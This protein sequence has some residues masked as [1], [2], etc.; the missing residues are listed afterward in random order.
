LPD[1]PDAAG[2]RPSSSEVRE[3]IISSLAEKY[4]DMPYAFFRDSVPPPAK[5]DIETQLS[6]IKERATDLLMNLCGLD[7][8]AVD[9]IH[10]A[11]KEGDYPPKERLLME[12]A[13]MVVDPRPKALGDIMGRLEVLIDAAGR[14]RVPASAKSHKGP[15]QKKD[16][17]EIAKAAATDYLVLTHR[18]PNRSYKD[19][20]FVDFL[21]AI[22]NALGRRSD[23]VD[24]LAR[25]AIKWLENDSVREDEDAIRKWMTNPPRVLDEPPPHF[26]VEE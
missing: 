16:A 14:A 22:F 6:E 20:S 8:L 7:P 2:W 10:L 18:L 11:M 23:S 17:L 26:G 25:K 4:V 24:N 21:A 15:N 13:A 1:L 19:S 9:A 5:R 12:T 3:L